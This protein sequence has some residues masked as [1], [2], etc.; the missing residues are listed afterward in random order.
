MATRY[1]GIA[2]MMIVLILATGCV[3]AEPTATPVPPTDTA[4]P[5]TA[6][7]VPPTATLVPPTATQ[8][9]V[10]PTATPA[11]PTD[12]PVPPTATPVPPTDTPV[13]PTAT[14]VPP[15]A[16]L[17]RP[18]RTPRPTPTPRPPLSGS[19]GGVL[20][21]V[22]TRESGW[23]IYVVN[24]DGSDQR[25]LL[26]HGQALA[27]PEWSPDGSQIAF[28]K[29]QS[30]EVVSI[31]VMDADGNNE[32]RLT[33]TE[34]Y[35]AAP[36]WSPDGKQIAF[37]RDEDI[38]L[39][40]ADGSDQRLLMDDPVAAN[41]ADWSLDGSRIVFESGRD[42]NTEIYVMDADGSN[43]RRLTNNEAEDWWPTWSPDGSQIA[44]MSTL[45]GDWEIYVMDADGGN[46]RQL[47]ENSVDD[48]GPAWSPD[49][50]RIAFVSNRDTGLPNDTEIYVMNADS[51]DQQRIIEKSGFEW[52]I[53]WR[54]QRTIGDLGMHARYFA[55]GDCRTTMP[56]GYEVQCG[57]LYVPEDRS[58]PDGRM[59]R[60]HVAIFRSTNP[61]PAPDPV[62][63][64]TG[65]GGV[66]TFDYLERFL[67]AFGDAILETRDLIFF[68]QRGMHHGDPQLPC[69]GLPE[70]LQRLAAPGPNGEYIDCQERETEQIAFFADCYDDLVAQ[71]I[72]LEM[73]DSATSAADA[74]DL[75]IA[76][77]YDQ[78]NYY[79][80]SYG[81][82]LGLLLMRDYPEGA[83][84]VVLDSVFPP[85]ASY[86]NEYGLN[87]YDT[88]RQ[89]F[90]G[91]TADPQCHAQHPDLEATFLRVVD[92]LNANPRTTFWNNSQEVMYDG[93]TFIDVIYIYLYIGE[94]ELAI[95]AIEG[96][97]AGDFSMPD[98]T[99]PMTMDLNS[100]QIQWGFYRNRDC[101]EEAP[102]SS[103][104]GYYA[105]MDG[106]PPQ[107]VEHYKPSLVLGLC[108]E[109]EVEPADPIENEPVVSDVPT[110]IVSGELDPI[111]PPR[112]AEGAAAHLS[113]SYFYV[114]PGLGHGVTRESDCALD[115]M[116]EFFDDPTAEPDTSCIEG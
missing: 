87:A 50:T 59:V 9:P 21:F 16:T 60:M 6:T 116:L 105:L 42:G 17:V 40:N 12:T 95:E 19:G 13:P 28:H 29:H 54:P 2:A 66:D 74:N 85:E 27:Y 106:L 15:T 61:N 44:F 110:L 1:K 83:R 5:P 79:G 76:L 70:L 102:F 48:R 114:F 11:L 22:R 93:G 39:M 30:D 67:P 113:N 97:G 57:D 4:A 80:S 78:V 37:T 81:T 7:P 10:P 46:L 36:F 94:P 18:T 32:R 63:Y 92:Y 55:P 112:W 101:R 23:G 75:R 43:L 53:D 84:S 25:R 41:G 108:E 65:G 64:L 103:Y 99:A 104:E 47:T 69:P 72:K 49:G 96:A 88:F 62:I 89:L 68:N 26:F 109:W 107:I 73:Y 14:P 77:G 100:Y 91:C 71:G 33:H 58:R 115:I 8:T 90:D 52:G 35:D 56:R 20:A 86:L 24:A 38:W 31:N 98:Y 51:T 45:D 34:T 111:T 3:A 82:L